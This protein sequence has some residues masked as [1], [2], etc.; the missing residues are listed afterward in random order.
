MEVKTP[1]EALLFSTV[2]IQ[3][4]NNSGEIGYGTGFLFHLNRGG[5]P[6]QFII[7][8]RHV[9]EG[10]DS[11]EFAL[12]MEENGQPL[13]GHRF[14]F[15]VPDNLIGWWNFHG[16]FDLAIAPFNRI[17]HQVQESGKK[18]YYRSFIEDHIPSQSTLHNMDALEEVI[19]AGYPLGL[20]DSTNNL[21]I[22]RRGTTATPIYID[23]ENRKE[24]LIDASV[25]PGS[26]GSPVVIYKHNTNLDKGTGITNVDTKI[27]LL[28]FISGTF[29]HTN[30]WDIQTVPVPTVLKP[31]VETKQ[32]IDL[33][34][35]IKSQV[36]VEF[37]DDLISQGAFVTS[38]S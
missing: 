27:Y 2:R 35:V 7:T 31:I 12:T 14:Y 23:Y 10:Y 9:I 1:T 19:F 17:I 36:I 30:A 33:G 16:T 28:G 34:I 18:A 25:F 6:L 4:K 3:T 32:M 24:F 15:A 8:N 21:P 13:L 29:E 38:A 5:K 37:I 20:Y 26:S 22:L 11:A